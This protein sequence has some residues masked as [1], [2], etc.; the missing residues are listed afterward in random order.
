M[1]NMASLALMSHPP[2]P[3]LPKSP[4][5]YRPSLSPIDTSVSSSGSPSPSSSQFDSGYSSTSSIAS[6]QKYEDTLPPL[7]LFSNQQRMRLRPR[8]PDSMMFVNATIPL[9]PMEDRSER[10]VEDPLLGQP[11]KQTS[12]TQ[13]KPKSSFGRLM[14]KCFRGG[15]EKRRQRDLQRYGEVERIETG[16]WTDM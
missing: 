12:T 6:P 4:R 11:I 16:H 15:A 10:Y 3:G 5:H 14:H 9:S 1:S 8:N 2:T 13:K 7:P